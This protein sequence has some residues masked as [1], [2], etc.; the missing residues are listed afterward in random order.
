MAHRLTVGSVYQKDIIITDWR[1]A[2]PAEFDP[3][4]IHIICSYFK[5]FL[6]QCSIHNLHYSYIK[7]AL[8]IFVDWKFIYGDIATISIRNK[9]PIKTHSQISIKNHKKKP[10]LYLTNFLN[11]FAIVFLFHS[12]F[13]F[14]IQSHFILYIVCL[15]IITEICMFIFVT[16][17]YICYIVFDQKEKK[18]L[19]NLLN[20]FLS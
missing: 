18:K 8:L 2:N 3:I 11:F 20:W 12:I 4:I 19:R 10:L 14:L 7:C 17:V 5:S 16:K 1:Y 15:S 9:I 13:I 6:A